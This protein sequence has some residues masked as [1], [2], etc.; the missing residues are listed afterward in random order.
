[1]LAER[2]VTLL[3]DEVYHPLYFGPEQPS[4]ATIPGVVTMS[5]LSKALSVPGLRA[6]WIID[7]DPVR[8][9]RMVDARSYFTISSSPLL[10][11]VAA[12]AM[13]QRE[14]LLARLRSTAAR[15]IALLDALMADS[16]GVLSWRRP[17]GGTTAFPWFTDGRDSRPFCE[18]LAEQG[19][20]VAPGDCF[21]H[22]QHMRIGF[23]QQEDGFDLAVR[24]I[25]E[26][27][28]G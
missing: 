9:Q 14:S 7:A 28:N 10:E 19:V 1:M 18:R 6:G 4:A 8:R 23:A 25:G 3:V 24:R 16:R 11:M 2:G 27:L 12:H 22:A 17:L 26:Q 15:N 13:R 5:D 21:G 20:L